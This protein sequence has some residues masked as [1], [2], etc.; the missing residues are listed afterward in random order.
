MY[1]AMRVP[2]SLINDKHITYIR[3]LPLI[4]PSFL[5]VI[6]VSA[7]VRYALIAFPILHAAKTNLAARR[8]ISLILVNT[9]IQFVKINKRYIEKN[10]TV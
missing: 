7:I 3:R 8:K 4:A 9:A 1:C 2:I 10:A 6:V 5:D